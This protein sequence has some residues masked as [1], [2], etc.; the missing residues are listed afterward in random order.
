MRT[1]EIIEQMN[2]DKFQINGNGFIEINNFKK[3]SDSESY[4]E[5]NNNKNEING[6][7]KKG[8][9]KLA[10]VYNE[11]IKN[12]ILHPIKIGSNHGVDSILFNNSSENGKFFFYFNNKF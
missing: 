12:E 8:S 10:K 1:G 7:E 5:F 6:L 3:I 4:Y 2:Y 9:E 11:H